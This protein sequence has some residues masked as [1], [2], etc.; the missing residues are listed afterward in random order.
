MASTVNDA[1]AGLIAALSASP[2]LTGVTIL[3]GPEPVAADDDDS[4]TDDQT[5][6]WISIGYQPGQTEAVNIEYDWAQIGAQRS[7]ETYEIL[8][9]AAVSSGDED[10]IADLRTRAFEIRDAIAAAISSDRTLGGAVRLA[11]MSRA[12]LIQESTREGLGIAL[13]FSVACT[14]RI[15]T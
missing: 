14:A 7:E 12:S 1:I 8:C 5:S 10:G 2:D 4:D 11:H 3:D 6:A 9:S 13:T 15:T